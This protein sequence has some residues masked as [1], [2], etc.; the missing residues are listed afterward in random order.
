MSNY[1]DSHSSSADIASHIESTIQTSVESGS[2]TTTLVNIASSE[3]APALQSA[4]VDEVPSVAHSIKST[5]SDQNL[6]QQSI[7]L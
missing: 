4:V 7:L 6:I 3:G 1:D 2:F 5:N